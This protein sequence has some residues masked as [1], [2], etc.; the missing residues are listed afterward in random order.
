MEHGNGTGRQRRPWFRMVDACVSPLHRRFDRLFARGRG[1][2]CAARRACT[3]QAENAGATAETQLGL[4]RRA[5]RMYRALTL[6]FPDAHCE[7]D[8]TTSL[9]LAVAT[10]LSAQCTDER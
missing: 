8:F 3:A 9:E 10:I 2:R 6:A 5:R 7:L 1:D 4:V